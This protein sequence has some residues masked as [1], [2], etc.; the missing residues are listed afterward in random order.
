MKHAELCNWAMLQDARCTEVTGQ[1]HDASGCSQTYTV[2]KEAR[3]TA[4][5]ASLNNNKDVR[6]PENACKGGTGEGTSR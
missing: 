5:P 6:E 4:V 2:N 1:S 3:S